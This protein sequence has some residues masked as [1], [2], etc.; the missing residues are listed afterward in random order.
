M[1]F[2][3]NIN[4]IKA[5]EKKKFQMEVI[6][7]CLLQANYVITQEL[8]S[9]FLGQTFLGENLQTKT[10]YIIKVFEKSNLGNDAMINSFKQ[11]LEQIKNLKLPHLVSIRD[12]F[13]LPDK[14]VVVRAYLMASNLVDFMTCIKY[15]DQDKNMEIWKNVYE[16]F[17]K[18]HQNNIAPSFIKPTNIFVL[19]N[20]EVLVT[21]IYAVPHDISF[22]LKKPDLESLVFM[23]PEF[24][25]PVVEPGPH[26]DIWSLAVLLI[27]LTTGVVPWPTNNI[28][29]MLNTIQSKAFKLPSTANE[30]SKL[31]AKSVFNAEP[32]QRKIPKEPTTLTKNVSGA[33][34]ARNVTRPTLVPNISPSATYGID[35]QPID[36]FS[37]LRKIK[38]RSVPSP[39]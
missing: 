30:Y 26:S 35:T 19:P 33:Q 28:F 31:V 21:D 29:L 18:L 6:E 3:F 24:F 14:F 9:G 17:Q 20:F 34:S 22:S 15:I 13:D 10:N 11:R 5:E 36:H 7:K 12:F 23:A 27:Y 37:D 32:L 38:I 1:I 2:F 4:Y 39:Q 25:D 8:P 16:L